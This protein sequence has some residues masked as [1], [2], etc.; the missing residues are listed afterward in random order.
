MAGVWGF[1]VFGSGEDRVI[2]GEYSSA[3]DL[4]PDLF[5]CLGLPDLLAG[6]PVAGILL[7]SI[8]RSAS[9]LLDR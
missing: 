8:M 7:C 6:L 9:L 5:F 4:G 2:L 1:W 3:G